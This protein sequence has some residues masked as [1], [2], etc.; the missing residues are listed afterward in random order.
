MEEFLEI[1]F[2]RLPILS[3]QCFGGL[4]RKYFRGGIGETRLQIRQLLLDRLHFNQLDS[5]LLHRLHVNMHRALVP[6]KHAKNEL[7]VCFYIEDFFI[8]TFD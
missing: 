2:L 1:I 4:W 5:T 8:L 7:L 6:D 3:R